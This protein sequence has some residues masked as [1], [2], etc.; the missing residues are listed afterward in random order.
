[1][2]RLAAIALAALILMPLA[3]TEPLL[4]INLFGI[5]INASLWEGLWQ[6]AW[7]GFPVTATLVLLCAVAAP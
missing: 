5:N 1:M 7:Q 3:Y 6:M 4:K 2:N